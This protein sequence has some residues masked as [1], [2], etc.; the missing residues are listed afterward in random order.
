MGT[1]EIRFGKEVLRCRKERG[2][3][4][5]ELA[6]RAEIHS[7]YVSQ[8]ERGRKSPTLKVIMRLAHALSR[9]ASEMIRA[10]EP[11]GRVP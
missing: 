5:E 8:L 4:Q 2:F 11:R 6:D 7:T 9:P 10:V 1:V 3:T